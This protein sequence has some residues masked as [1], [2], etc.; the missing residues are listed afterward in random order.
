MMVFCISLL[1]ELFQLYTGIGVF[2]VD[3]LLLNTCGGMIGYLLYKIA[4]RLMTEPGETII[5]GN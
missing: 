2:D 4:R 3:D 1:F 5:Q